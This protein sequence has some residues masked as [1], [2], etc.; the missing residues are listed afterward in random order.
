VA[1]GLRDSFLEDVG[2]THF[3]RYFLKFD[4]I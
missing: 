1:D 2:E 3:V 4:L